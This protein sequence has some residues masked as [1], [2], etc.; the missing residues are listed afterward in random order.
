MV[1]EVMK[2]LEK[3]KN[4]ITNMPVLSKN[5]FSPPSLLLVMGVLSFSAKKIL[6][7]LSDAFVKDGP[8]HALKFVAMSLFSR[9]SLAP[10]TLT[11][12]FDQFPALYL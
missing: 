10:L 2:N 1:M 5:A 12:Y 4:A 11:C 9:I 8:K 7:A 3:R 6:R